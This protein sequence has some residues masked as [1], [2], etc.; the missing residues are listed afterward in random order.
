MC[1]LFFFRVKSLKA[2]GS[3]PRCTFSVSGFSSSPA[4]TGLAGRQVQYVR[5]IILKICGTKI[6]QNR[7]C[8]ELVILV[9]EGS[10]LSQRSMDIVHTPPSDERFIF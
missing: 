1:F 5:E 4:C 3:T 9:V 10:E 6:R 8:S 2:V 7:G